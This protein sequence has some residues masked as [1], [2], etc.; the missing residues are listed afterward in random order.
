MMT[1]RSEKLL[2]HA[3][4]VYAHPQDRLVWRI[5]KVG[6]PIL[7]K[8]RTELGNFRRRGTP[9]DPRVDRANKINIKSEGNYC[10]L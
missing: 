5:G 3:R 2:E 6:F 10:I 1:E 7:L 4:R 9:L 8:F